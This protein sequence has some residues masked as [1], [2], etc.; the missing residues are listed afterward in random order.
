MPLEEWS[1]QP[2]PQLEFIQSKSY[3]ALFGGAAGGGKSDALLGFN[4]LRRKK[5]PGSKGL[6]LRTSFAELSKEGSL[7][8]RS[9]ELLPKAGFRWNGQEHKWTDQHN[10]VIEFGYLETEADKYKYQS[11]AYDDISFDEL[12]HRSKSQYLYMISRARS[13]RGVP[14]CIR[15]ATNP[16]GIGHGWVKERFIKI[17]PPRTIFKYHVPNPLDL[18]NPMERTRVFIPSRVWDNKI[19]MAKD[20]SYA[21]NLMLLPEK[22]RR[23]LLEGDWDIFEGQYFSEWRDELHTCKPFPIPDHW[24][25]CRVFDWGMAKPLACYWIAID[26]NGR[27]WVYREYYITG[28]VAPVA[29]EEIRRLSANEKYYA[30]Y[31]DPS[32][33]ARKGE[34]TESIGKQMSDVLFPRGTNGSIYP[35]KNERVNGWQAVHKYFTV[36]PD[37]KPWMIFF[38]TCTN[39]IRTIP[40][41]VH[42]K[43]YVEDVDTDGEDH[44]G[45]AIRYFSVMRPRKTIPQEDRG[46]EKLDDRSREFWERER[47]AKKERS[48]QTGLED[49]L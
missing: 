10:G 12:T 43:T 36:A 24:L 30:T 13:I 35:A 21:A 19:L 34:G 16:G 8:P 38:D 46:L 29:A 40:E 25:R 20:P 17:C 31:A 49:L 33:F 47:R 11:S 26:E 27:A 1:P 41:L 42:D 7:I 4:M 32:I 3:E 39:A 9:Q 23:A 15:S 6:I 28:K 5:Y 44:A 22:E 37:G 14:T 45:D 48:L 2:G 18:K